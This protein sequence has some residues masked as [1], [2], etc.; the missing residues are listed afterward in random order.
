M[1]ASRIAISYARFS[2]VAQAA[3]D[4][5]RR[6]NDETVK[7]V[8]EH[9][10]ILDQHLSFRDLGVSAFDRSNIQ[11]GALGSFLKAAQDGKVPVGATLIVESLDR[12]SRAQVLDALEVFIAIL[13]VGLNIVTLIDRQ[14]Y[15][16][17]SVAANFGQLL[18]SIV[19][20]QRAHEES[21]TKSSR[22]L[23][24]WGQK[25]K[26][27]VEH[28]TP[29]TRRSPRWV[30]ADADRVYSL[31][32]ERT[33]VVRK[34][35]DMAERGVGNHTIIRTLHADGITAWSGTGK[36][37]PSYIQK[38]LHSPALYGGI[39]IDGEITLGYY[40]PVIDKAR[41]EYIAALR[42][43]RATTKNTNR[44][45]VGVTNLFSGLLKCGY[46]G[47][48]MNVAGY[49]EHARKEGRAPYE[50]KYVACHGARIGATTCK[51]KMWFIDEL[52]PA[53]LFW[54]TS[55][56]YGKL[57][58]VG[59]ATDLDTERQQL[60]LLE[61]QTADA[62]LRIERTMT[63]IEE[64]ASSMV[65]R[66]KQHEAD[67][68]RLAALAEKQR[69]RVI[70]LASREG[71]SASRMKGL[72]LLF[73]ALKTTTDDTGRRL[74]REQLSAAVTSTVQ[75]VVLYPAGRHVGGTKEDRFA[76]VFFKNGAE[77]RIEP[78]EL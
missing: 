40:P 45:G 6:Q 7:Y 39:D 43:E 66:L 65:P 61:S 15:S 25:K 3:G 26:L 37:Q 35:L 29:M 34:I 24:L 51:M 72:V 75:R 53:L 10:L 23:Q 64:G 63:A 57:M 52:E 68:I 13:N 41:F 42:S 5:L 33:A 77:R 58:N 16:R 4:S 56:D 8:T 44:K 59:T 73:R 12:L 50:R 9:G 60:S 30:D 74:L 78:G 27:A 22:G 62:K 20:M 17:E 49:K 36:W 71:A 76:D 28:Q 21:A 11:R 2:S 38:M 54:L 32:P 67:A 47:S 18:T 14:R 69:H 19:I 48:S 70:A 55:L 46:C 31:N 1:D